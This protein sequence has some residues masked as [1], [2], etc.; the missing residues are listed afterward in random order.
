MKYTNWPVL[1]V[2]ASHRNGLNSLNFV[3]FIRKETDAIACLWRIL[4]KSTER[5]D[6]D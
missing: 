4:T 1:L 6:K 2:S 3:G 5:V